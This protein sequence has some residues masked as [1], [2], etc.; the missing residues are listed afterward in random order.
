MARQFQAQ[1]LTLGII[2]GTALFAVPALALGLPDTLICLV[3]AAMN[4]PI[5]MGLMVFGA[6][7]AIPLSGGAPLD[8]SQRGKLTLAA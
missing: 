8:P 6:H 5:V 4:I 2:M 3:L 1:L 7:R